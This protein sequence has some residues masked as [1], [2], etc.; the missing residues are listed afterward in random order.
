MIAGSGFRTTLSAVLA[1]ALGAACANGTSTRTPEVTHDGLKRVP[2]SRVER[3]WVK[4]G[5]D[6]SQY[7]EVGL[8]DCLVSFRRNWRMNHP[9][10]RTRDMER[11]KSALADEF[12]RVFT[13]ELE[14]GG[15]PVVTV[16]DDHVLLVRPAIIDLDVAA[17]DTMSGGRSDSFTASAGS[18][19]LVVELFDSVSNE[20]LARAIDR[21]NARHTG[22]VRWTTRGSNTND[23]RRL[24]RRWAGLLV[25]KL[26]EVHGKQ[27]G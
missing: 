25:S 7:T 16:P 5:V 19:T 18:M 23:A 9:G 14:R 4:P 24:L 22:N 27:S 11:I 8:L 2:G 15:Y 13:K 6:F 26:D 21:R 20:I 17:P 3:A 10:V 1:A 12:R